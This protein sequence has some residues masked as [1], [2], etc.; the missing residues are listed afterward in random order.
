[1]VKKSLLRLILI[2]LFAFPIHAS[3]AEYCMGVRGNGD[4]E[5]AHWGAM[6]RTVEQLGLP[7]VMAGGSSA[8][9]SMFLLESMAS[10]PLI[11]G[12]SVEIQK[13]RSSLML[14]SLLGFMS[15]VRSTKSWHDMTSL[16]ETANKAK[17]G[18]ILKKLGTALNIK[19]WLLAR[20]VLKQGTELGFIDSHF[21]AP[22]FQA[23]KDR[24]LTMAKFYVQQMGE[25]LTV[26]GRFDAARDQNLFFRN[27]LVNFEKVAVTFGRIAG[28]YAGQNQNRFVKHYW[29]QF[30]NDCADQSVGKTWTELIAKH[31]YCKTL[32]HA[33]FAFHFESED[34]NLHL[35]NRQP[36]FAIPVLA[37]NTVL[38]GTAAQEAM[39]GLTKYHQQSST[40]Y[41]KGFSL[42]NPEDV[43]FA[44]WGSTQALARVQS[45]IDRTDEK[46]RRFFPLGPAS[47]KTILTYSPAEPGLS[48]FTRMNE[49]MVSVG[50]WSDLHPVQVLKAYGCN[51]IVYLT[52]EGGESLFA[53]GVAKRLM[54]LERDW[55]LLD[56]VTPGK[57]ERNSELNKVGDPSDMSSKWSQ[58][59]NLGNPQSSI[60]RALGAASAIL[61]TNWNIYPV[62]EKL[63]EL[64]ETSYRSS[65][66]VPENSSLDL[67][68][69][70]SLPVAGC[71]P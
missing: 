69:R 38:I 47:W 44:Y 40:E 2:S 28:F 55:D 41:G 19:N 20:K 51:N 17:V 18:S 13:E 30:M 52:R 6:A 65:F 54:K 50:G 11:K 23:I 66:Y 63:V 56:N 67:K 62:R 31:P 58:L 68:P 37:S 45:R 64:V 16:F 32:F 14:K 39:D 71:T 60:K 4:S 5:P 26:L 49:K 61:C 33:A 10:N 8:T 35:E 34:K 48:P 9:Y 3:A 46:S 59:Y 1:M 70:L 57:M 24:N 53:Q 29:Q 42:S 22:L 21:A 43:K 12:Q 25:T 15:E 7:K 27:G 36:G